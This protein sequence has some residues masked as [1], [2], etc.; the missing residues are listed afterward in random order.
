M[1][2]RTFAAGS[3]MGS[4]GM[5]GA[6]STFSLSTLRRMAEELIQFWILSLCNKAVSYVS[7]RNTMFPAISRTENLHSSFAL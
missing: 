4:E 7:Y 2:F 6:A 5:S 3:L 1:L